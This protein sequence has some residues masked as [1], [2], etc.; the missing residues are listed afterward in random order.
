MLALWPS[1]SESCRR[2]YGTVLILF[3]CT[4]YVLYWKIFQTLLEKWV[5]WNL[6]ECNLVQCLIMTDVMTFFV[7]GRLAD[8]DEQKKPAYV[9]RGDK[10]DHHD[11]DLASLHSTDSL[12]VSVLFCTVCCRCHCS[13]SCTTV[14]WTTRLCEFLCASDNVRPAIYYSAKL[15]GLVPQ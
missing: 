1:A 11:D 2:I 13:C 8:S 4:I 7:G 3:C 12:L 15:Y 5:I 10:G 6:S 9:S 14:R